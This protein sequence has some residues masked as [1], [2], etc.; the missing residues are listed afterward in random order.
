MLLGWTGFHLLVTC[1][2]GH[3]IH[4][5]GGQLGDSPSAVVVC[6]LHAWMD[7]WIAVG[8]VHVHPQLGI[9]ENKFS[10]VLVQQRIPTGFMP[11]RTDGICDKPS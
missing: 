5:T 6:M 4:G 8:H 2:D 11:A 7:R 9:P 10:R 1:M 3:V